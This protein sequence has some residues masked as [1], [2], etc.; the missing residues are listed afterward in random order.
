M[1]VRVLALVALAAAAEVPSCSSDEEHCVQEGMDLAPEGIAACLKA[2][3]S[4]SRACTDYLKLMEGCVADPGR[5]QWAHPLHCRPA[6]VQA[7][8]SG[9]TLST[10]AHPRLLRGR[11]RL[12]QGW[13]SLPAPH[14]PT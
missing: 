5:K 10:V 8:H 11:T 14:E 3:P 13:L 6:T 1:N 12:A 9:P 2:L 4:K 7:T